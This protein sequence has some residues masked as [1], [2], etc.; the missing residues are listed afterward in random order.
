MRE[1]VAELNGAIVELSGRIVLRGVDLAVPQGQVVTI[2]GANGSG[3]TTLIR[4]LLGLVPLSSGSAK[5]FGKPVRKFRDHARIGF[6]PQRANVGAGVPATVTE[7]VSSGRLARRRLFSPMSRA[8]RGVVAEAIERV[9]LSDR[10]RDSYASLSGGMQQR[11]LIARALAGQ[12]ELFVLDEPAA[13][14]DL[15]NQNAMADTLRPLVVAGATVILVAHELGPMASLIDRAVLVRD[16]RIV[17]DGDPLSDDALD[18]FHSHHHL[19][20]RRDNV[21]LTP[22]AWP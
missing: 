8:E 6:V 4:A 11:V 1:P 22:G 13:G 20:T 14:V 2:L 15:L 3:K 5:L 21:P 17:H 16:G 18:E 12:P 7:I 9:G 10:A 19:P